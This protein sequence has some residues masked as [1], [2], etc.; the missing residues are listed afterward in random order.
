MSDA[1]EESKHHEEE[2]A[3]HV[4]TYVVQLVTDKPCDERFRLL[5]ELCYHVRNCYGDVL[6]L[7]MFVKGY[8][9][10]S[11]FRPLLKHPAAG[12]LL[13]YVVNALLQFNFGDAD[14][15]H[16]T[17][18]R[19]AAL[20]NAFCLTGKQGERWIPFYVRMGLSTHFNIGMHNALKDATWGTDAE[21]VKATEKAK[22]KCLRAT[23]LHH[24]KVVYEPTNDNHKTRMNDLREILRETPGWGYAGG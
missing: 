9:D 5:E 20:S 13:A 12:P 15:K 3:R 16:S 22:N 8:E 19:R 21:K 1:D 10:P 6:P 7:S 18:E 4:A 2:E 17:A 14:A 23:Y 11:A 24:Y